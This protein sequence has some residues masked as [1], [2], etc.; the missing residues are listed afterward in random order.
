MSK[1]RLQLA[2]AVAAMGILAV[3]AVAS[4][5]QGPGAPRTPVPG[6]G[7][8]SGV[9]C[10]TATTCVSVGDDGNFNGKSAIINAATGAVKA[11]SGDL[12]NSGTLNAVACPGTKSCVAV[13]D[14]TVASVAVS[15]GAMKVTATP[16]PPTNGIVALGTIACASATRCYAAGFEG[17]PAAGTATVVSLSAAGKLLATKQNSGKGIAAIACPSAT[18]CLMGENY[19]TGLTIQLLN[20]GKFGA[21][22]SLPANTFIAA[23][24]CFKASVCYALG[25]N[26]TS[27]PVLAD[28]LFPL[29]PATGAVGTMA[30]IGGSFNGASLSCLNA[31]TCLAAGFT[32]S[33]TTIK[34]AAVAIVKGKPGTPKNYAGTFGLRSVACASAS[35]CYAVGP[36]SSGTAIVDKVKS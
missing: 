14:D 33:G 29:N 13:A 20:N 16:P 36:S 6:V 19:S 5:A 25:G 4:A 24:A 28:E 21:K 9:T 30:T 3:P 35:R 7:A 34:N 2:A 10:P 18:L 12:A 1:T 23:I 32:E 11:W 26:S 8:L 27:S 22:R 15:G 17:S 31:T